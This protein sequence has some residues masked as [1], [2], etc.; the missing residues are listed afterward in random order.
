MAKS[1]D[2]KNKLKEGDSDTAL[3]PVHRY[4]YIRPD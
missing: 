1:A 2:V 4:N 3:W